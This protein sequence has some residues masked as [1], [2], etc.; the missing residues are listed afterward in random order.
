MKFRAGEISL[1][2][3]KSWSK[4]VSKMSVTKF[5]C[6]NFGICLADFLSW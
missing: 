1:T 3:F 4:L 2:I 5:F 6:R